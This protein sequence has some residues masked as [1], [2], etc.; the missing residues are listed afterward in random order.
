MRKF[1]LLAAAGLSLSACAGTSNLE[2]AP[3]PTLTSTCSLTADTVR[4]EQALYAIEVAYNVPA[5]AYVS[6]DEANKLSDSLKQTLRPKLA[7]LYALVT[8]ARA[9][10]RAGDACSLNDA[11]KAAEIISSELRGLLPAR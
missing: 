10:Y 11:A 1:I 7:S 9:A 4:D 6:L 3:T 8:G 2:P 5:Q